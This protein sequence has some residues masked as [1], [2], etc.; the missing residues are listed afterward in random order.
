MLEQ[1]QALLDWTAAHPGWALG[2]LFAVSMLDAIFIIGAFV[3][4]SI[5]LFGIGALVALGSLELWPA[6]LIAACGALAGDA[7]SFWL[8]RRYGER[9]FESPLLRRYPEMIARGR[10]FFDRHGGK[11][12]WIAR[13]LGPVRSITPALAGASGM[14][15][16]L[17]LLADFCAAY[18]WALIYIL[19][20]VLFGAS[21]GL[22]AEVA[23]RLAGLL[24]LAFGVGAFAV[25]LTRLGMSG[26][27]KHAAAALGPVLDWSRRHRHLGRF[28]A[29]L[30]DPD[31][32]E[33]PVLAVV[34]T[35]LALLGG[36]WLFLFAD[37]TRHPYPSPLDA[38][39]YQTLHD[40][41]TPW[42]NA[43]ALAIAQLGDAWV[44]GPVGLAVLA[45][46]L[47]RRK[48]RAA[49]HWVAALAF[50]GL[51][52]AGLHRVPTLPA[53][54]NYFHGVGAA[55]LP[56]D[57]V[58]VMVIYGFL[59]VLLGTQRP[60]LVRSR[61]YTVSTILLSLI[62]LARLYLGVEWWSLSMFSTVVALLWI[63][64]LGL[65]YRR[66]RP[67]RLFARSFL[68]PVAIVFAIAAALRWWTDPMPPERLL[69]TSLPR[70]MAAEEWWTGAYAELPSHRVDLRGRAT[71]RFDLQWAGD[72]EQIRSALEADGWV[73]P[74]PPSGGNLLRWLTTSSRIDQL[75]VLP[76]VHAGNHQRL[77]LRR[78]I[79]EQRQVLMRLWPSGW[80]L[81]SGEPIWLG[82]LV[83]QA[84]R[85][86][87]RLFRYPVTEKGAI[88]SFTPPA[89]YEQRLLRGEHG[90][91]RL[92]AREPNL[93]TEPYR[94]APR[95]RRPRP[96]PLPPSAAAPP[97]APVTTPPI[98][99]P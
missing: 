43:L 1:A 67:D 54:A 85:T 2:L 51:I 78:P 32:P 18:L 82:S 97:A 44:Y 80:Q 69:P 79:D 48:H 45:A 22:A 39:I 16:W 52:S 29:A 96:L 65:G 27:Q 19:P 75:P 73:A 59:P 81:D 26:L 34:A 83:P 50:G 10:A 7:V 20:G 76:Q 53:P 60:A 90:A 64:A 31:Q 91:L 30:A 5:V 58:M 88:V 23:T 95:G 99:V 87:Y 11:G 86:Y 28:G 25:W 38:L 49:A 46:L 55:A 77:S 68:L 63:S 56:R 4:A 47:A 37:A 24:V 35:T 93:Y 13:F 71:A 17:F 72:L 74:T 98:P 12:V 15:A 3:P 9:L 66:H 41:Q 61:A 6:A 70:S 14:P 84:A 42:G 89:P 36:F 62:V 94:E 33:T 57:L 40:L 21:M 8:G 92:I